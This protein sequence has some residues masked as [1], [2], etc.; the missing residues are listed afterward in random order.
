MQF[1]LVAGLLRDPMVFHPL[2]HAHDSIPEG[3]IYSILDGGW[4]GGR[5]GAGRGSWCCGPGAGQLEA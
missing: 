5:G 4:G 1:H 3:G 2:P